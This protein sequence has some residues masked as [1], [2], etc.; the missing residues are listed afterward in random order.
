MAD[1]DVDSIERVRQDVDARLAKVDPAP[2]S[3]TAFDVYKGK[4]ARYMSE[5]FDESV[6]VSRRQDAD[7]VSAGHVERASEYLVSS[8]RGRV[9]RHVGTFG[10]IF[11]GAGVSQ[12]LSMAAVNQFTTVGVLLASLFGVVGGFAV[13]FHI[14]KD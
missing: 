7:V 8:A 1:H 10:G 5:L 9:A 14:A 2:F 13:A 4:V 3:A 12:V 11:L 6:K